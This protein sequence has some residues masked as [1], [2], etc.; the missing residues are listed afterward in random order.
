MKLWQHDGVDGTF[1]AP[2]A[3]L[4]A[5]FRGSTWATRDLDIAAA[6]RSFL[7]DTDGP[8]S[9]LWISDAELDDLCNRCATAASGAAS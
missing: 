2:V 8:I 4:V 6:V 3:R 5:Q 1:D 7:T 9:A